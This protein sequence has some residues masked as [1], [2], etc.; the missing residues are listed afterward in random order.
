M[1]KK[2]R[3]GYLVNHFVPAGVETF[4]LNLVNNLD[5]SL[6]QPYLY[7]F[8]SSADQYIELL[9]QRVIVRHLSRQ[10]AYSPRFFYKVKKQIQKD[11]IQILHT[12]NWST[13]FEGVLLKIQQPSL[14]MVYVQHGLEYYLLNDPSYLKKKLRRLIRGFG[15]PF[16]NEM[17]SVSKIGQKLLEREWNSK[18]TTL[19]YN[20][21][22]LKKFTATGKLNREKL[23][24]A[25]NAFIVCSVGRLMDVKNYFCLFKAI[26]I[27]TAIIPDLIFLHIGEEFDIG[28]KEGDKLLRFV[29]DNNLQNNFLFL[30]RRHD[31]ADILALCDVFSLTSFSEGVSLSLLEAQAAGLPAVVTNVGGNPEVVIEGVNGYLATS[32]NEDEVAD[33]ILKLYQDDKLRSELSENAKNRVRQLFSLDGMVEKYQEL[34]GGLAKV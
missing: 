33:K 3:V 6:Y 23:S 34:Y 22:D 7:V 16:Y 20:G 31:I 8:Y 12:N 30:G 28:N 4:I 25:E 2:I 27:L 9:D 17:V 21:I 1:N 29:N 26:K 10:S 24:I 19:I 18:K 11:Q 15:R 13:F 32:N 14:K 5:K